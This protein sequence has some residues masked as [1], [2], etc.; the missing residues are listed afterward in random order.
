[1]LADLIEAT[2]NK[3]GLSDRLDELYLFAVPMD[4]KENSNE[5]ENLS[6]K[7]W[8]KIIL[9]AEMT[10]ILSLFEKSIKVDSST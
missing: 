3:L 5:P 10:I 9:L 6:P 7:C 4:L 8:R 1:L 2:R